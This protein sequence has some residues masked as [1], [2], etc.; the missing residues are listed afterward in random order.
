MRTNPALLG[1]LAVAACG[2][3][4]DAPAVAVAPPVV[5]FLATDFAF[6]GPEEIAAGHTTIRMEAAASAT[7][8][9]HIQLVKLEE[10][11]TLQDLLA[12][13]ATPG[14]LPS[15]A[16]LMGGPNAPVPGGSSEVVVELTEGNWAAICVIPGPGGPHFAQGM[17][18]GFTVVPNRAPAPAPEAHIIATMT[19]YGYSF[20]APLTAG[21]HTI[22]VDNAGR[23]PHELIIA[24][25]DE[26]KTAQD[27]V[28]FILALEGHGEPMPPPGTPMGGTTNFEPGVHN[29]IT[30]TLEPG[31]YAVVCV[32]PDAGDG[33]PHMLHG[34][35]QQITVQ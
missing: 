8:L 3:G 4:G 10:G 21:T 34:M 16:R 23:Q 26:G 2:P 31:E 28:N 12:A 14:P 7:E 29:W 30:V 13:M 11:R 33:R 27:M 24:R 9:H 35:A 6:S 20:S 19:E 15:W 32:F 5:T 22:R 17:V 25:L 18:H 1:L